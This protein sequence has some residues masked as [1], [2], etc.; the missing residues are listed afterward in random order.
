MALSFEDLEKLQ[1]PNTPEGLGVPI[2]LTEDFF[3]RKLWTLRHSTV[4]EISERIGISRPVG[5]KI[6]ESLR[7]KKL[8]MYQGA[9][10]R[11]YKITLTDLGHN[12]TSERMKNARHS[13]YVPVPLSQYQTLVELQK[14]EIEIDRESVRR[15]FDDLVLEDD[16]VDQIGPAM[17]SDGAIL[18][19]GPPG[20]GKS[21]ISERLND[22]YNDA[23]AV[24]RYVESDGQIISVFDPSIH[25]AID[26]QPETLDPRFVLCK[27]PILMVG[28][29]LT[30]NM[31][32]LQYDTLSGI[33]RAP[34]QMLANNG[35]LVI[36][37]FGRQSFR[38]DELLNRWILPLAQGVD[39]LSASSGN[40][41]TIPF[42][43]KLIF[44][45][46]IEPTSLGDEA[47]L[48]R[49]RSKIFV[50]ACTRNSFD[51]VLNKG[52][53]KH[54]LKLTEDSAD[55]V[56]KVCNDYHGELRPYLAVDFCDVAKV[57]ARY[58]NCE[59]VLNKR[60][61]DRVSSLYFVKK[62]EEPNNIGGVP[63]PATN[64]DNSNFN[65]RKDESYSSI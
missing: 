16:L 33:N 14:P 64:P 29:E 32:D 8:L 25:L 19:Y 41:I 34:V 31:L 65:R 59:L 30:L 10:G 37:D 54:G 39:F 6:A 58:D 27:R 35:I 57:T 26:D 47:F 53:N 21:T 28:G 46:N 1:P 15:A 42:E 45:T 36:D 5:I 20:T 9:D 18:I 7:D 61:I 48:R 44:S 2:G 12:T 49:L 13:A 17:A 62:Q 3:M 51:W 24:P 38:P 55:M 52:A 56:A 60:L 22:I 43:I 50:G 23:I 40:K 63:L 11:D 4:G